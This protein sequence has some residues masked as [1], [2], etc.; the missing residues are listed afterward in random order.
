MI[1]TSPFFGSQK[2]S[3]TENMAS[4]DTEISLINIIQVPGYK[5]VHNI[6]SKNCITVADGV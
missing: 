5:R 4:F 6:Y 1:G 3:G 2:I